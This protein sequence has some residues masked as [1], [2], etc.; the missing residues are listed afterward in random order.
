MRRQR[1]IGRKRV[2]SKLVRGGCKKQ[3]AGG[4]SEAATARRATRFVLAVAKVE[5][6][7]RFCL[8]D[9]LQTSADL[10]Q[11]NKSARFCNICGDGRPIGEGAKHPETGV[12]PVRAARKRPPAGRSAGAPSR[13]KPARLRLRRAGLRLKTARLR[14]RR[15]WLRRGLPCQKPAPLGRAN[16]NRAGRLLI[17]RVMLNFAVMPPG[18]WP[19]R[20]PFFTRW[21]DWPFGMPSSRFN[22]FP[23]PLKSIR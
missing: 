23:F 8:I 15:A 14:L 13:K 19:H 18:R 1:P 7:A 5:R 16:A 22:R 20:P 4:A 17:L 3:R 12:R 2:G 21:P 9:L 10:F 6:R 11:C